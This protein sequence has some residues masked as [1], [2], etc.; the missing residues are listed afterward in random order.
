M[1]RRAA[2][3][4]SNH[5]EIVKMLR[6]CA[7]SVQPLHTVGGG[8]P[9]LLCGF[10]GVNVLLEVKD[11]AKP[12]SARALTADEDKWHAK[13]SGQVAIVSTPDEAVEAVLGAA[14]R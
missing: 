1:M 4:D 8:V 9:D 7:I 14:R 11:G 5:Q 13:W 6:Q 3:T 2:R 10:R 12:P